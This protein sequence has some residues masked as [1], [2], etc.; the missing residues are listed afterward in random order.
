MHPEGHLHETFKA[1]PEM[2]LLSLTPHKS[3]SKSLDTVRET[4][5]GYRIIDTSRHYKMAGLRH[6][7]YS[8]LCLRKGA[9]PLAKPDLAE[10]DVS[11]TSDKA[12]YSISVPFLVN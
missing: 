3:N 4:D 10:A 9:Q 7:C 5:E 8:L 2:S 1:L 11:E 12:L 6:K